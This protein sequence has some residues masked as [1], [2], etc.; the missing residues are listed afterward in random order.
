MGWKG[1]LVV[2]TLI[3]L[4][5]WWFLQFLHDE[6]QLRYQESPGTIHIRDYVVLWVPIFLG[7]IAIESLWFR[8][9]AKRS[10]YRMNDALG[11]LCLGNYNLLS[12]SLTNQLFLLHGPYLYIWVNW[13][14]HYQTYLPAWMQNEAISWWLV[15]IGVD[16]AYYWVHRTGHTVNAFWAMHSIHHSSEEYNLSTAL[17]QSAIHRLVSWAYYLP[18]A[19]FFP[20]AMYLMHDQFNL[21][22]QYWIH[23]QAIGKLGPLEYILNTPSQHRVHHGRNQYCIDKNYG[24]TLC[25][26]DRLFGTFQ[27]EIEEV[28]VVFGVTHAIN[29]FEP[30]S[31]NVHPWKGIFGNMMQVS[32]L[33]NKFYCL[34]RGPGWIPGSEPAE[35]YSIPPCTRSSVQKYHTKLPLS[36][37]VYLF[38]MFLFATF[39]LQISLSALKHAA[40]WHYFLMIFSS[41]FF[42]FTL[43][44]IG[45]SCNKSSNAFVVQALHTVMSVGLMCVWILF[46]QEQ[47]LEWQ[48]V[49]LASV[50]A[51]GVLVF[52]FIFSSRKMITSGVSESEIGKDFDFTAE[53]EALQWKLIK[54]KQQ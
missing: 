25:I 43:Y 15:F 52:G 24:G 8:L 42:G 34:Y 2:G 1:T 12:K 47:Y 48:I 17:R 35:E 44:T 23:T 49:E 22:Y 27:E 6:Y 45:T 9:T 3:I 7:S 19:F 29:T 50:V 13:G 46:E 18:L 28:P 33:K 16:F 53:S 4:A 37:D 36:W 21:L 5:H 32:G 40:D 31:A 38:S 11:S 51:I 41:M 20:P 54:K 30:I 26:F 14:Q 10:V 39:G